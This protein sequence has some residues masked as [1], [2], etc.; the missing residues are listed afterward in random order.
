MP[1]SVTGA[2]MSPT[3]SGK[4]AHGMQFALPHRPGGKS[5]KELSIHISQT[6][7]A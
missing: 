1:A 5:L 3:E 6:V 7:R 2:S 4:N